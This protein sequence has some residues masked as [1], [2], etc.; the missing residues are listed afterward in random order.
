MKFKILL[1]ILLRNLIET[2]VV[3]V[4]NNNYSDN[5][6]IDII[7]KFNDLY[8]SS[9]REKELY[10]VTKLIMHY[11]CH[12][13]DRLKI[14]NIIL[15]KI[16]HILESYRVDS[17]Q[18]S[19]FILVYN[20]ITQN[21]DL[22]DF[23][24][25][26][27]DQILL[28]YYH[29]DHCNDNNNNNKS[30]DHCKGCMQAK[31][32]KYKFE[33]ILKSNSNITC[34]SFFYPLPYQIDF[35]HLIEA[36]RKNLKKIVLGDLSNMDLLIVYDK[37]LKS[38]KNTIKLCLVNFEFESVECFEVAR[39][40]ADLKI[41]K[42]SIFDS[43]LNTSNHISFFD[44]LDKNK[45]LQELYISNTDLGLKDVDPLV[46]V[47]NST[48]TPL[49]L[50]L[51]DNILIDDV[52]MCKLLNE[53]INNKK[54]KR[55]EFII[56]NATSKIAKSI[57]K[58]CK[59][60]S[61]MQSIFLKIDQTTSKFV[62]DL[63]EALK[64]NTTLKIFCFSN[65]NLSINDFIFILNSILENSHS[66]INEIYFDIGL[67]VLKNAEENDKNAFTEAIKKIKERGI[68]FESKSL[69]KITKNQDQN[70]NQAE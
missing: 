3:W 51:L 66:A 48:S 9:G 67:N 49:D 25:D 27:F 30:K 50:L 23:D 68:G 46:K 56:R 17:S 15:T 61:V 13:D 55:F 29:I 31:I 28:T 34:L 35:Y 2:S 26:I 58:I 6:S 64:V 21:N 57:S 7:N 37:C 60:N 18:R 16:D 43:D 42:L 8:K 40:L 54:L 12:E 69:N 22:Q 65:N 62:I 63:A 32:N 44:S 70:E 24:Q 19:S 20:S 45:T 52:L 36:I 39:L 41:Y 11:I 5:S 33:K 53:L 38:I 10:F 4:P 47:L 14:K 59:N 1:I